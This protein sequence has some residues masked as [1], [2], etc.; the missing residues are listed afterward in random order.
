MT[1]RYS[2]LSDHTLRAA[3]ETVAQSITTATK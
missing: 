1:Q 2:H 3:S